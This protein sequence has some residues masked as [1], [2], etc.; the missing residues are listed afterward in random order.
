MS[1]KQKYTVIITGGGTGGHYYPAVAIADAIQRLSGELLKGVH[2]DCHYIGS[3]FGIEQR[4][5]A[6][7]SYPYTLIPVKGFSRYLSL[8]SL[9]QNI[10]LPFRLIRSFIKIWAV[11]RRL[12]P[13]ATIATGGY[14][15][16][17]PGYISNRRHIP[18]FVQE[19]NAFPGVTSRILS[20]H[21]IGFFYAYDAV[22]DHIKHDVLFIKS[23]NPIRSNIKCMDTSAA[24][25]EMGLNLKPFTIFIFGG[26]Q[27]SL[28]I[29]KYI[30]KHITSWIDKYNIQVLWQT[31]KASYDMLHKQLGKQSAVTLLPYIDNMSAAYSAADMVISRAGALT[32][33][34]IEHM[35]VPAILI[36]LPTAAGNHQYY[37]AKSLESQGC[38]L[39]IEEHD[40]PKHQISEHIHSMIRDPEYLKRM[41]DSFPRREE[42][43]SDIIA[44]SIISTLRSLYAW[45]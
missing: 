17:I 5:A 9:L 8:K 3:R 22:K 20:K 4:L 44:K 26:S 13:I 32:L 24:R 34:E 23:G 16:G 36:P 40:F 41:A 30:A 45:S 29:N 35:R 19:Q 37:N 18:L 42:D 38:A 39:I 10:I 1:S 14:V 31:G 25:A 12:D 27:G 7:N 33:A 2:I 6:K 28:G 21:A 11:Y 15:S 43:T